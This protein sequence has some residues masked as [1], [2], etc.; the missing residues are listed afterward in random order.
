MTACTA[1]VFSPTETVCAS[2]SIVPD[3]T[4]RSSTAI[5][6]PF[7]RGTFAAYAASGSR[8]RDGDETGDRRAFACG[9]GRLVLVRR[10]PRLGRVEV[11]ELQDDDAARVPIALKDGDF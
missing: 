3:R 10:V 7:L 2:S 4:S 5:S 6:G 1:S 11:G 9:F 8:A